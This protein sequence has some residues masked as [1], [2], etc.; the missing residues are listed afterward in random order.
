MFY[1]GSFCWESR[2]P[3]I[4]YIGEFQTEKGKRQ[5]FSGFC[6]RYWCQWGLPSSQADPGFEVA[7]TNTTTTSNTIKTNNYVVI[8]DDDIIFIIPMMMILSSNGSLVVNISSA[9]VDERLGDRDREFKTL[10][11]YVCL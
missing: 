2:P 10:A 8:Y 4:A 7:T 3:P 1:L 9:S 6:N 11:K 5:S